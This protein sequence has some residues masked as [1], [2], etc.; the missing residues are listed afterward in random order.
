MHA[1]T[2]VRLPPLSP[3]DADLSIYRCTAHAIDARDAAISSFSTS[4]LPLLVP[5]QREYSDS[6][7]LRALLRTFS[8]S[9]LLEWHQSTIAKC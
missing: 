3:F 4:R 8:P 6:G 2:L 7:G 9:R 1:Y 5:P